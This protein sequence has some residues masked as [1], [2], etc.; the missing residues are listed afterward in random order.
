ML[1]SE[2]GLEEKE[3][4]IEDSSDPGQSLFH[5]DGQ[6]APRIGRGKKR[7]SP[8]GMAFCYRARWKN[9]FPIAQHQLINTCTPLP[10]ELRA[11]R[12][13]IETVA[14]IFW[15]RCSH[16]FGSCEE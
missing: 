2:I 11:Q 10:S 4:R 9:E 8:N 1:Y 13:S 7:T 6:L 14:L 5:N 3:I 16:S 15:K 12:C